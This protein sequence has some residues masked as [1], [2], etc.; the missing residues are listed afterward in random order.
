[1]KQIIMGMGVT[2]ERLPI[3]A[4]ME[5]GNLSDKTWNFSFISWIRSML[6]DE[7]WA[8]L[9]YVADSALVTPENVKLLME[10]AC[11][12]FL[13]RLP[14]TYDLGKD[15]KQEAIAAADKWED[16]GTLGKDGDKYSRY[17]SQSFVRNLYGYDF[18][19]IVVHS[20]GLQAKQEQTLNRELEKE[21][22]TVKK[23]VEK[24]TDNTFSCAKDAEAYLAEFRKQH[25][26]KWHECVLTIE[27]EIYIKPRNQRGRPKAGTVPEEGTRYRIQATEIVRNKA[28]VEGQRKHM[29]MFVLM[30]SRTDK[31]T[32]SNQQA[33]QTYKGQDA[34]ETRFRLLKDPAMLD[35]VYLKT[36]SRIEALGI[37]FVMALM[38]YGVLEWRVREQM[39]QETQPL[40]VP[41][42]RKTYAPTGQMLLAILKVF[43]VI[44]IRLPNG[45]VIRQLD[46]RLDERKIRVLRLAG[47]DPS[48]YIAPTTN[49]ASTA[50]SL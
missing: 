36:P 13:T 28:E 9:T 41:G 12:A 38:V 16:H 7:E 46:A 6:S 32:W 20:T 5:N 42:K 17:R 26:W 33:L 31:Q 35:A 40:V 45:Q 15:L 21:E 37:V 4:K 43:Q 49:P 23:Q 11:A 10:D 19:F 44:Y 27:E 48:I 2:P 8:Q 25:K 30:T 3:F 47:F 22:R 29:G 50:P 14:D 34:A 1:L 24:L 18:R 39:K